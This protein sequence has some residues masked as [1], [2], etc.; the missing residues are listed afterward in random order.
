ML[1]VSIAAKI[2]LITL[3]KPMEFMKEWWFIG[4]VAL[5]WLLTVAPAYATY[6]GP[7]IMHIINIHK[8][9]FGAL[10]RGNFLPGR[11]GHNCRHE[12]NFAQSLNDLKAF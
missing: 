5:F 4:I 3:D 8:W 12:P 7:G 10:F 6:L 1:F 9:L 11:S 2:G